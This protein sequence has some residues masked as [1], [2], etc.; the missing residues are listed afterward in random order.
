[1]RRRLTLVVATLVFF[2]VS[3]FALETDQ[4]FAWGQPL[5][6]ETDMVNAKVNLEI[7]RVL[8]EINGRRG[9]RDLSCHR[10]VRKIKGRF[11]M[12]IF[13]DLELWAVNTALLDRI[14]S[15]ADGEARFVR[16]SV[17]RDLTFIDLASWLPHSPTIRINDVR[18]GTDK[19]AH[20]FSEGWWYYRFYRKAR[21]NG[22]DPEEA[23][24][25]AI[26]R[27]ILSEKTILGKTSSGVFSP[28]DLEANYQ[29]MRFL[30]GLCEGGEPA[31]ERS[32]E[33]WRLSAPFDFRDYVSPEWDESYQPSMYTK[34]VWS[35]V[36]RRDQQI[37][38]Q[39]PPGREQDRLHRDEPRPG[40]RRARRNPTPNQHPG[41]PGPQSRALQAPAGDPARARPLDRL[42]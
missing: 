3:T 16:G 36:R 27:G 12:F 31:L 22:K 6:D 37:Q 1:M 25:R 34:R 33:G 30:V 7:S 24:A 29:G 19:F 5:E 40:Q 17:Y 15:T 14:P 18:L 10:L 42:R 28:A 9:W 41:A 23:E 35:K 13:T 32:D 2:T 26:N 39:A 21:R 4:F 38:G 8:D 11:R 20:F